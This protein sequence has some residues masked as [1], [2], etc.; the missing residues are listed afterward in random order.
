ME[1]VLLL[2]YWTR[3]SK[4]DPLLSINDEK[5][6]DRPVCDLT[7]V[8]SLKFLVVGG[9]M[10]TTHTWSDEESLPLRVSL[11]HIETIG[12]NV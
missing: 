3:T 8:D 5:S 10:V 12:Q 6:R 7:E 1:R 9:A 4:G 11:G 2:P